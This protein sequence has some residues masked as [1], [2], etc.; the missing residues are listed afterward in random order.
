M[1]LGCFL[2]FSVEH[3]EPA[4]RRSFLTFLKQFSKVLWET[5]AMDSFFITAYSQDLTKR[6]LSCSWVLAI[7]TNNS[8]L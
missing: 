5:C 1:T 3:L 2:Q 4:A 8:I 7:F 6:R